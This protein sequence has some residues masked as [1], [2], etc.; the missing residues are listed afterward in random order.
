MPI[1]EEEKHTQEE[2]VLKR[3]NL[4]QNEE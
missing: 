4:M 2:T 3:E 1:D